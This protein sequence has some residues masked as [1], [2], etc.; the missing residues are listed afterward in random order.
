MLLAVAGAKTNT[1]HALPMS[2]WLSVE[3]QDSEL[4]VK[5]ALRVKASKV[6]AETKRSADGVMTT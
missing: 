4:S 3:A 2:M 1:S 6:R 5:T